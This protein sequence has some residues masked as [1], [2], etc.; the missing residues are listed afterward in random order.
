LIY[1]NCPLYKLNS[2]KK[3]KHVLGI[4]DSRYL[5][6]DFISA[7]V[8]PYIE[9]N[10]EGKQRLIEPP[11]RKL[12]GIQTRIKNMLGQIDDVPDYVFSGIRKRSY[13]GNARAH[14]GKLHLFKID[15]TAF[16]PSIKRDSVYRFFKE[17]LCCSPDIAKIL[18]NFTTIDLQ[19]A[20]I[21]DE[22]S[23]FSFLATKRTNTFNHLISGAPTSSILS[24]LT[25]RKMFEEL[26]AFAARNNAVMT[27]YVDDIAFSGKCSLSRQFRGSVIQIIRKY[28]YQ[29]SQS[30]V[31]GYSKNYAKLVT[32]V[33]IDA[34]GKLAIKNSLRLKIVTEHKKLRDNPN[35][36]PCRQR[37]R[38]LVTA[39]RQ[40]DGTSYP[41]MHKYAFSRPPEPQEAPD[42]KTDVTAWSAG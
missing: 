5:K 28:G 16:F 42:E 15:L 13:V 17:E 12:K 32:G 29:I 30:K 11:S 19:K 40:V 38:G 20:K 22:A 41:T 10:A 36:T 4:M 39:A 37:L 1:I 24:Y 14:E 25:N 26:N 27:I 6:Q 2:K 35:D 23:V 21:K 33:I 31:K 18:T 8:S 9:I 34:S 7:S 3:L